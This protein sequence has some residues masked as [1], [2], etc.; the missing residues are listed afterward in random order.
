MLH[1]SF[2]ELNKEALNNNIQFIKSQLGSETRYS[3]VVKANAYGHGI[4][5]LLPAIEECG[6]THFSVF[7]ADEALYAA[8]SKMYEETE[9]M[10]MGMIDNDEIEIATTRPELLPATGAVAVHPEDER[11]LAVRERTAHA[12]RELVG[13]RLHA[14]AEGREGLAAEVVPVLHAG[15]SAAIPAP[16]PHRDGAHALVLLQCR[17]RFKGH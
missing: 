2:I 6:V 5:Q 16:C 12:R 15:S 3:M 9:L 7:S 4:E 10:I 8:R 13:H 11:R 17:G 14:G 1:T